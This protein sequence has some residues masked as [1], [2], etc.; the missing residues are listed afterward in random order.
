MADHYADEEDV[1]IWLV[2]AGDSFDD[3]FEFVG[4]SS[5][6]LPV[7][8]DSDETV[9]K[10]YTRREGGESYAPFPLQVIIDRDGTIAYLS[11]QYDAEAVRAAIDALL[12]E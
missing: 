4:E 3:A 5:T 11:N 12:A 2:D 7:L 8:L 10:S 1:E 6:S 9:Y